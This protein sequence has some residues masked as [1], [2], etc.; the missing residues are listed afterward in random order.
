M[1]AAPTLTFTSPSE[2]GSDDD[3]AATQLGNAWDM[4]AV[5]DVDF[6]SGVN[7]PQITSLDLEAPDGTPLPSQR[8]F[9]GTSA[10]GTAPCPPTS[11]VVGDPIVELLE[12][13]TRGKTRQIDADRYRILTVEFGLLGTPRSVACG[14]V[15][16]I[17]WRQKGDLG[18]GSVSD[19]IIFNSRSGAGVL[20]KV[21]LDMKS[22]FVE[23]GTGAG[24]TN[25]VNGPGGGMEIF[26]FDPHEFTPATPFFI[27]RVKLAALEQ[28]K[29][30][31]TIRWTYSKPSG[32]V[33]LYY[34]TVPN[35]FTSGTLID[36]VSATAGQYAWSIPQ[37]LPTSPGTPYYIYAKV[38]DGTNTNQVYAKQPVV[39]DSTFVQKPRLVLSRSSLNF[40]V[41]AGTLT[42]G[43][44]TVR[45]SFAGAG[46]PACWT[47]SSSNGNFSVTPASGTGSGSFTVS[48][49]PQVFPGGGAGQGIITVSECTPNTILNPGQ[50]V[51]V[52]YRIA[53]QGAPP[54][55]AMD[56][57]ADGAT[58]SGSI[59]V[60]GWV[61]DDVEATS[62]KIYRNAVAGEVPDALGRIFVGDAVRVDDAR[63]DLEAIFATMPRNYRGGWGYLLLTNF[64]PSGGNG[65]FVLRAYATDR[66]GHDTLIGSKTI[67]AENAT[68]TRPFGAIDTP[69]QGESISG[70]AYN[71]FGWVLARGPSMASPVFGGSVS[72]VIDGLVVGSP[73]SWGNRADL[74]GLFPAASY[75]G[76]SRAL[77]VFTFDTTAYAE[78]I[79]TIAWAVT[80][81]DLQSDGIGSRYFTVAN[82]SGSAPASAA[83]MPGLS[84]QAGAVHAGRDLGRAAAD[85]AAVDA[86]A[87]V[88]W[89][90]GYERASA[91]LPATGAGGRLVLGQM[92]ER[93]VVDASAAGAARY[94]AYASVRGELRPLPAGASFDE[95]RGILYWQPGLGF[96]GDYDF[97]I[98]AEGRGRIPVRVVLRPQRSLPASSHGRW[99][100]DLSPARG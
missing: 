26:R 81:N 2:E 89:R 31:Y 14:S 56:T 4:N 96:A 41:T 20:D 19:D 25:W 44:Q 95:A 78:G 9:Y 37:S 16:R 83:G 53:S 3:F 8:V 70:P 32:T 67:V 47:A 59:A 73:G 71:N 12:N 51:T 74:D 68:A 58:V 45:V 1:N 98:V 66:E 42:T 22:L 49:V 63:P 5:S 50:Q 28:A 18:P 55:G 94:E 33:E 90:R 46:A 88:A 40:G 85:V 24:G 10:P 61:M 60:T 17:V 99:R 48:L 13:N 38:T 11:G 43:S 82:A 77:G 54:V 52:T 93:V 27:K 39:L 64:L 92:M 69:A 80:T 72:V 91:A 79:H 84:V 6:L 75:P 30:T 97:E 29:T 87:P 100:F 7:S 21:T 15:A 35:D 57:P 36:I 65:T 76:V 23:Q 34:T 62:V 86:T